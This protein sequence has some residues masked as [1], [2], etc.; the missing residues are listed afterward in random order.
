MERSSS[1]PF[2]HPQ[3][4]LGTQQPLLQQRWPCQKGHRIISWVGFSGPQHW[5]ESPLQSAECLLWDRMPWINIGG[6]KTGGK[7]NVWTDQI[8]PAPSAHA[9]IFIGW[10]GLGYVK[11]QNI[12][13][14]LFTSLV[15]CSPPWYPALLVSLEHHSW[16]GQTNWPHIIC[17]T[18]RIRD[19]S[20]S[21]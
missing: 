5:F 6:C 17:K 1:C 18:N 4:T 15:L 2:P 19:G 3:D 14:A 9:A 10:R 11:D 8:Q 20:E 13:G 21:K 12:P 7:N 16:I